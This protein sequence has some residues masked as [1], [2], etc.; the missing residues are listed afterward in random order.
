MSAGRAAL[1]LWLALPAGAAMA[2]ATREAAPDAVYLTRQGDTLSEL[3]ERALAHP[4]DW[5]SV[6][7]IN[8]VAE[9]R[10]LPTGKP[11]AIPAALLKREP[12]DARIVAFSGKV[13]TDRA[14]QVA[15]GDKVRS[16]TTITTGT[17]SFVTLELA[18]GSRVTLPSQSTVRVDRLDRVALDGSVDRGF[19]VVEG[20]ADFGVTPRQKPADRFLVKT[21][22]AVAA[23]RGTEFRVAHARANSVVSV[24]DGDVAGRALERRDEVTIGVAKGAVLGPTTT[25]LATLLPPPNLDRPGRLQ[26][27]PDVTFRLAPIGVRRHVQLARDAG[28]VDLFAEAESADPVIA[29]ADVG[30]GTIYARVTAIDADGVEGL[31]ASY[32]IERYRTGLAAEAGTLPGK[33]R[34]TRFRW[35]ASGEGEA[36]FD[37]VLARDE[38][39]IDRVIDAPGLTAPD[40]I[41]TGLEPRDWYWR[42]TLR[43]KNAGRTYEREL[44]VQRL[45]IARRER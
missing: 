8:K 42:V 2:Q 39:L 30:N 33:P 31:P 27:D 11:L 25:K 5:R 7:R 13:Q 35:Q 38:A 34:R 43:L 12:F 16:G 19:T 15:V 26:D 36:A 18:D 32:A 4:G 9:P 17:N 23:V 20:R 14:R 45:T 44:P 24:V 28:F 29:F 22:V 3:G 1:A 21:P 37:F 40:V 6:A 10:K 41:V